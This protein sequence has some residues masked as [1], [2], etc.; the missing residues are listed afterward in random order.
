MGILS[1]FL[2]KPTEEHWNAAMR[3]LRYLNGTRDYGLEFHRNEDFELLCYSDSDW[4]G[5]PST[6]RS[7]GEYAIYLGKNLINWKSKRQK[8]TQTST[9]TAEIEALYHGVIEGVWT[10]VLLEE[11][12]W[13]NKKHIQ[14]LQDN[15]SVIKILKSEK[16]MEKTRHILVKICYLR[17]LIEVNN[18]EVVYVCSEEN[19]AD[20]F[21]KA[22][23]KADFEKH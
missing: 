1:R 8:S 3:V 9:T 11:L 19:I 15:Q 23:G 13:K 4:A 20:V 22:L 5:D 2:E 16:N 7:V 17:E 12:K 18:M 14:W 6:G 10:K 21:T